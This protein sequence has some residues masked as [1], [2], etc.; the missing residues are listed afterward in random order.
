[1]AIANIPDVSSVAFFTTVGPAMAQAIAGAKQLNPQI[2]GLV[3]QK[4]GEMVGSGLTNLN[5]ADSP[6]ITL[7][8]SSYAGLLGQPTGQFW[9]DMIGAVPPGI[10]VTKP[11]GFHPE[12]P[13]PD[14]LVLD[15]EEIALV[16]NTVA[17]FNGIIAQVANSN[18]N[19]ALVDIN[20]LFRDIVAS[21]GKTFNG[22]HFTTAFITGNIFSYDGVHPTTQGYGV[23]ANE[24]I[25]SINST[26]GAA[27][28]EINVAG[29]P[30]SLD[31][32]KKA[33][34]N[35]LGLPDLPDDYVRKMLNY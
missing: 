34:V 11:F 23:V 5:S 29:L 16:N 26:F 27:I 25:K 14:A 4:H 1:M 30:A 12:N 31:L 10:D 18:P 22:I 7:L 13:W 3:Y 28:P 9:Q 19:V 20:A 32:A 21:G 6:L 2:Q 8:G 24:F 35:E 17:T 33:D 15:P